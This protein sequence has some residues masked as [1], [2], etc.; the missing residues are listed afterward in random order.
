MKSEGLLSYFR[1][2]R[3]RQVLLFLSGVLVGAVL[4][5]G[6][7]DSEREGWR[8]GSAAGSQELVV[9]S[10]L[11]LG[12]E[13]VS[14]S[15]SSVA[16]VSVGTAGLPEGAGLPEPLDGALRFARAAAF[17]DPA[18]RQAAL[19][20]VLKT[21]VTNDHDAAL[22]AIEGLENVALRRDLTQYSLTTLADE[23]PASAV[24]LLQSKPSVHHDH[25]WERAFLS[26][27]DDSPE[28]AVAAW[29]AQGHPEE[30]REGLKGLANAFARKD[31]GSAIEWASNLESM[32]ESR[33]AMHQIV[34]ITIG[35]DPALAAAHIGPLTEID[36][37]AALSYVDQIAQRWGDQDREAAIEWAE[38]LIPEQRDQALREIAHRQIHQDPELAE[39]LAN[40]IDDPQLRLGVVSE[41]GKLWMS[42]GADEAAA[43]INDLPEAQRQAAWAGAAPEWARSNPEDAAAFALSGDVDDSVQRQ[44]IQSAVPQW[45]RVNPEEAASW[46]LQLPDGTRE[47]ALK[48]VVQEWSVQDP[49]A[50][51][52]FLAET[53]DDSHLQAMTQQ[54]V[55]AWSHTDPAEAAMFVTNLEEGVVKESTA[56]DVTK[57]WMQRNSLEASRWV[58]SLE[59]SLARDN[60]VEVLINHIARVEPDSA[61][62]WAE[63]ISDPQKRDG[64]LQRLGGE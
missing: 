50:T 30:R 6:L 62:S 16:P 64:V 12:N 20:E 25:L 53:V 51:I 15:I 9:E 49:E 23:S 18:E 52:D 2:K 36:R 33:R 31:V 11:L 57:T 60:A 54:A 39:E 41:L 3:F 14:S 37:E 28:E 26:W 55:R 22:A 42:A 8:R 29:E 24:A 45:S 17:V 34:G 47:E 63:M 1:R 40:R 4:T 44:L 27:A 59:P 19:R 13:P 61:A 56:R 21:W 5:R 10:E 46:A 48:Q 43:W 35:R 7:S 32:E 38:A 58:A